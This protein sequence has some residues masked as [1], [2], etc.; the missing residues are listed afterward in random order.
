MLSAATPSHVVRGD[1]TLPVAE[2]AAVRL[3]VEKTEAKFTYVELKQF[4]ALTSATS[5]MS[6]V[7]VIS[8]HYNRD[9]RQPQA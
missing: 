4:V 9:P 6:S 7:K 8:A 2:L 1:K 3:L 5:L